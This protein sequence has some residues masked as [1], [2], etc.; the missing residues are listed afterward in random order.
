[1]CIRDRVPNTSRLNFTMP[2]TAW[3]LP[4]VRQVPWTC[5][6]MNKYL[7]LYELSYYPHKIYHTTEFIYLRWWANVCCDNLQSDSFSANCSRYRC[8]ENFCVW[9]IFL[10]CNYSVIFLLRCTHMLFGVIMMNIFQYLSATCYYL[11]NYKISKWCFCK[12]YIAWCF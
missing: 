4:V 9:C 11:N 8:A 2:L 1:M 12:W 7:S 3:Q 6:L 10:S 5:D